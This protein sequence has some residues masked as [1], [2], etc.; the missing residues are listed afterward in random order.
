MKS[1]RI[2]F[3]LLLIRLR[4]RAVQQHTC[5]INEPMLYTH[6]HTYEYIIK[7]SMLIEKYR[8]DREV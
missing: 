5:T 3:A 4:H 2:V 7:T 8:A 6:T 1:E